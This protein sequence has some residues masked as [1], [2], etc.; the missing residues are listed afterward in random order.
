MG[1]WDFLKGKDEREEQEKA[2]YWQ[3]YFHENNKAAENAPKQNGNQTTIITPPKEIVTGKPVGKGEENKPEPKPPQKNIFSPENQAYVNSVK[4]GH[5]KGT[6][7]EPRKATIFPLVKP[8]YKEK[9]NIIVFVV[10]NTSKVN[11]YKAQILSL[12]NKISNDNDSALFL[13]L[14][15][16]NNK[17]FYNV[18]DLKTIDEDKI[19]DSLLSVENDSCDEVDYVEVLKH[20]NDFLVSL[21]VNLGELE[22]KEKKYDVQN[23][24][25]I[26]IGTSDYYGDDESKVEISRLIRTIKVNKKTKT[27][28]YFCMEDKETINAAMLGFPVVGHI[29]SDFYK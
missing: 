25:I 27:I 11:N 29:V 22:Y 9:K 23:I 5:N 16:G 12:I 28:K 15:A 26:F 8:V 3:N 18:L 2:E 19:I 7:V 14:K 21:T 1:F 4:N 10:E 13:F 24:S 6:A 20:I 17:K